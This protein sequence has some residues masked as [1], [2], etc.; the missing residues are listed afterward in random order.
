MIFEGMRKS[1]SRMCCRTRDRSPARSTN[2]KRTESAIS[3]A[4]VFC[5]DN[6]T[7]DA[8]THHDQRPNPVKL[9]PGFEFVDIA[10]SRSR[11]LLHLDLFSLQTSKPNSGHSTNNTRSPVRPGHIRVTR[12]PHPRSPTQTPQP[13][14]PRRPE[15]IKK[16]LTDACPALRRTREH[17]NSNPSISPPSVRTNRRQAVILAACFALRKSVAIRPRSQNA[18]LTHT[19]TGTPTRFARRT[20]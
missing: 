11:S 19:N 18:N 2:E 17:P 15:N 12:L 1:T 6:V 16:W 7:S 9:R 5:A 3:E 4:R 20:R 13:C 8:S 14:A 10:P